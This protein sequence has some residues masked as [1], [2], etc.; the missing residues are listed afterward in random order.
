MQPAP[1]PDDEEQR[2]YNLL[3]YDILDSEQEK[4]FDDLAELS[5]LLCNCKY[6]LITF[7]DRDRH[8]FKARKGIAIKEQPRKISFCAHTILQNDVMVVYDAKKD[9]RFS[10]NPNVIDKYNIAFYAGAPI[11]SAAGYKLGTVC[12]MDSLPKHSFSEKHKNGLTIISNQVSALLELGIKNKQ[13][14]KQSDQLVAEGKKIVQQTLTEQDEEKNF[15]ANELHENFA[16]TLAATKLCLDFAE[17]SK[18]LS[19]VFIKKCKA[20]IL[21]IIKD[22]KALSRSILPTTFQN[23]NYLEFIE[24]MLDEYGKQ[25]DMIIKFTHKGKLD[26]YDSSIGL[27]LFR[28][29]QYQLKNAH[30]CGAKKI[31]I[32]IKTDHTIK[33]SFVDDG[34]NFDALEPERKMLLH[35]IK[36]RISLVNGHINLSTDKKGN[37]LLEIDIPSLH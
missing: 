9:E 32:T 31:A 23:A 15:I 29:I 26:C 4:D 35:H 1:F 12:V 34:K 28:I 20:N 22:I 13:A 6:A 36:T 16:Q 25:N 3:S 33:V 14:L 17:Q 7:M 19:P 24:E 30:N 2:I 21:Q 37:N 18:E 11:I 10:D 8:W 5:S 27:T